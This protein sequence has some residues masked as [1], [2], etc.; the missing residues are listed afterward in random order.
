MSDSGNFDDAEKFKIL[1]KGLLNVPSTSE[2]SDWY[3]ET[4]G[5]YESIVEADSINASAV[6]SIPTWNDSS[7]NTNE[8]NSL[9]GLSMNDFA[10]SNYSYNLLNKYTGT[11]YTTTGSIKPGIYPDS[12]GLLHLFVRLKLERADALNAGYAFTKYAANGVD[13]ILS[14]SF[15]FN[16]NQFTDSGADIQ[17][18][19]YILEWISDSDE[20]AGNNSYKNG[21]QCW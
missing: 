18:Y 21:F 10:N 16:Y 15:Q 8:M 5:K 13:Q 20:S 14:N 11:G 6:P 17:P 12:D 19:L 7:L 1:L 3:L 2:Y 4:K 9:Y